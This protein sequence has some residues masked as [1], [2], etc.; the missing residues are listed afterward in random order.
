MDYT[1]PSYFIQKHF[2]KK[3]NFFI[4]IIFILQKTLIFTQLIFNKKYMTFNFI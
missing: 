1:A 3:Y 2:Y 4:N